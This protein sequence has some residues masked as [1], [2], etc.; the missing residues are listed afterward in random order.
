MV[1]LEFLDETNKTKVVGMWKNM[2]ESD[3]AHFIN[4][5]AL[6]L[7]VLGSEEKGKTVVVGVL[8]MMCTNG[9]NTLADFGLY[10]DRAQALPEATGMADKMKRAAIII[11]GYRIKN[12]LPSE[13]HHELL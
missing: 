10:V 4:Q 6:A 5:V 12:G 11:E 3:K 9:T 7:S 2:S 13:P 1:S 8:Q